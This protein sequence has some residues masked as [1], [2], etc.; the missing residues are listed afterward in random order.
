MT[1]ED[2]AAAGLLA[3]HLR[4]TAKTRTNGTAAPLQGAAAY[5][6]CLALDNSPLVD[7]AAQST[8]PGADFDPFDIGPGWSLISDRYDPRTTSVEQLILGII[9]HDLEDEAAE[10]YD[11]D[12]EEDQP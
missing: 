2:V 7:L 8:R 5:V 9:E 11:D 4:E 3:E 12:N 10:L 6:E 1:D